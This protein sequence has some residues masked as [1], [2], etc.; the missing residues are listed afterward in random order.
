MFC[1]ELGTFVFLC[2]SL[3]NL[4]LTCFKLYFR[5]ILDLGQLCKNLEFP[6]EKL[7]MSEHCKMSKFPAP[8]DQQHHNC[9][10][11]TPTQNIM[12]CHSFTFFTT[13]CAPFSLNRNVYLHQRLQKC[14]SLRVNLRMQC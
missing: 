4:C 12:W 2:T 8:D 3:N 7:K 13:D 9:P 10:E 14:G 1:V 6:P 5:Q 11:S